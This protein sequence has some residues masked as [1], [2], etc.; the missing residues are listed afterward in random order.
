MLLDGETSPEIVKFS[1]IGLGHKI[2]GSGMLA[3]SMSVFTA[4][5]SCI[6]VFTAPILKG[7]RDEEAPVLGLSGGT[8]ELA[9]SSGEAAR[10][11]DAVG[12]TT[13]VK[14][15]NVNVVTRTGSG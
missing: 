5:W 4:T 9:A 2:V 14:D 13:D 1:D 7:S 15:S 11:L 3:S 10:L 8:S 6:L 12:G